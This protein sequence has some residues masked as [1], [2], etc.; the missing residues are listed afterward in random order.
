MVKRGLR[1]PHSRDPPT[2][3]REPGDRRPPP[4]TGVRARAIW[5]GL[6]VAA[7][8]LLRF[9]LFDFRSGDFIAFLSRWYD[10]FL[11]YGRWHGLGALAAH[12]RSYCYP[13]LYLYLIS[14]STLLPL[15]SLYAIKLLSIAADYAAAWYA[16]RLGRQAGFSKGRACAL[17]AAVL[18]LPTVVLNSALWGQCDMMYTC[19][20]LAS[21]YYVLGGRMTAAL[22]AFGLSFSMKPQGI[23]WCPFLAGLLA[24]G[25][26]PW[27]KLW[28]PPAVYVG[29]AVPA[30]LAGRPVSNALWGW[31][32][33]A[34]KP[35][36]LVLGAPNW[37]Q[38]ISPRVARLPYWTGV[39]LTLLATAALVW[40]L[41]RRA[42]E[43][44]DDAR[45]LVTA[46]L[47]SVSFPPFLLPGVHERYFF[48]ADVLSVVYAFYNPRRWYVP[49]LIQF[50]SAFSYLPYLFHWTPVSEMVLA[51]AMALAIELVAI[52]AARPAL[53][54]AAAKKEDGA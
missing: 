41:R 37:Y 7:S 28:I 9:S 17:M 20:L 50:G 30:T 5:L 48:A 21:L 45:W 24:T 14:L 47:L 39:A 42:A 6:S 33:A 54:R 43:G 18:F 16:W 40:L 4:W 15:S 12:L 26:L 13:Q 23:L 3:E 53:Q 8:V 32:Q 38:F 2:G 46:A 31:G 25:R 35:T 52:D 10:S 27:R 19:G 49:L 29:C 44:A 34:V 51:A 22:V 1:P 11:R 36:A